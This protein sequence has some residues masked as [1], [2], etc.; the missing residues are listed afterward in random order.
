[1]CR[2]ARTTAALAVASLAV[3]AVLAATRSFAAADTDPFAGAN[4]HSSVP[5]EKIPA[6]EAER[7]GDAAWQHGD[8]DWA[9][10]YYV[11]AIK[12]GAARAPTFAKIGRIEEIRGDAVRARLAFELAHSADPKDA[13]IAE[14]LAGF[15][16]RAGRVDDSAKLYADVLA[17]DPGDSRALDGMGE[18]MLARRSYPQAVHYFDQALQAK[19]AD[20]G[21]ILGHRGFA[22]LLLNDLVGAG[23]DLR[24]AVQMRPRSVAWRYLAELQVRQNDAAGAFASLVK[25]MDAAHAYNE[26]GLTFMRLGNYP[27]AKTYF[28]KAV[29]ASPS[30]YAEAETNLSLANE[31]IKAPAR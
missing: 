17:A 19:D 11:L 12:H 13:A 26:I 28:G 31:R 27:E 3:G 21:T 4:L 25:V 22:K 9:L 24:A 2:F 15:Y 14:Q 5:E 29:S 1:M 7:R 30:W 16:I 20:V 8:L 6:A 10:Y 23:S 18:I